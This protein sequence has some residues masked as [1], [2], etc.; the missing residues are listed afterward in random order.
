MVLGIILW[1]MGIEVCWIRDVFTF[2]L[3]ILVYA[4]EL[5]GTSSGSSTGFDLIPELPLLLAGT[6]MKTS[7]K[8]QTIHM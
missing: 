2:I 1:G 6:F 8:F 3:D 5:T 4:V 7:K